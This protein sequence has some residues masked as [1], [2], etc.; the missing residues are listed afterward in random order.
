MSSANANVEIEQQ[1]VEVEVQGKPKGFRFPVADRRVRAYIFSILKQFVDAPADEI[2]N[3]ARDAYECLLTMD[4]Y[5]YYLHLNSTLR[6]KEFFETKEEEITRELAAKKKADKKA[7]TQAAK[8][9]R[10]SKKLEKKGEE[11]QSGE[12]QSGEEN[13]S[14][15]VC[16][17]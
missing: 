4:T 15:F 1:Q 14:K 5:D 7:A 6:D 3:V 13:Q 10:K 17:Y 11:E 2:Q 9:P 16:Y 12:E 8:K